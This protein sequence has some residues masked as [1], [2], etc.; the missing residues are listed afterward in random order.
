MKVSESKLS[1][2]QRKHL[3]GLGHSLKPIILVG[4]SGA[5]DAVIAEAARALHDH[6]LVKIR[7]S[8]MER[9]VRDETIATLASRTESEVVGQIGHTALLFRRNLEKPRVLLPT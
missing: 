8:G 2:K 5:T 7:V 3:R 1:E 6:E 9:D 4:Q